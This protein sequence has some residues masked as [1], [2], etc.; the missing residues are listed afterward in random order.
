MAETTVAW[1]VD[2]NL[3]DKVIYQFEKVFK[4]GKNPNPD[5]YLKGEGLTR[6]RLL[7]ELLHSDLELRLRAGQPVKVADYL[8]RYPELAKFPNEVIVLLETEIRLLKQ[9]GKQPNP[10]AYEEQFGSLLGDRVKDLFSRVRGSLPTIPGYEIL[11][12]IGHG[13][14]GVVYRARHLLLNRE[15]ALKLIRPEKMR[16]EVTTASFKARFRR[17][18]ES[19]ASINHPHVVQ[20]YETGDYDGTLF[21]AMELVKGQSLQKHIDTDG[22]MS[23]QAA[24]AMFIKLAMGLQAVHDKQIIHRDLKPENILL[25]EQLEPKISDFGLARPLEG[26]SHETA[27][28]TP[29]GTPAYMSPEQ[30][31]LKDEKITPLVDIYGLGATLYCALTGHAPF[32]RESLLV[33]MEKVRTENVLPIREQRKEVPLDLETICLK[34]LSKEQGRRYAD[35]KV[36][37]EELR[38]FGNN[39]PIHARPVGRVEKT[40]R[41]CKRH[42]MVAGLTAGIAALLLAATAITSGLYAIA[43]LEKDRADQNAVL[44]QLEET[45]AK[46]QAEQT[47]KEKQRAER[48]LALQANREGL[49]AM[50]LGNFSAGILWFTQPLLLAGDQLELERMTRERLGAYRSLSVNPIRLLQLTTQEGSILDKASISA[51]G[52]YKVTASDK[53]ARVW[54]VSTEQPIT[55]PLD[56]L[57]IVRHAVFSPDGRRVATASLDRTARIWDANTGQPLGSILKHDFW[58]LHISFSPDGRR[59]VTSSGDHTARVWD[60]T[61]GNPITPPLHHKYMVV[62]AAF[63]PDGYKVATASDDKTARVWDAS[64]GNPITPPLQHQYEVKHVVFSPDGRHVVTSSWDYTAQ[65]WNAA[66]GQKLTPPLQHDSRVDHAT[67]SPDCRQIVTMSGNVIRVWSIGSLLQINKTLH[68]QALVNRAFFNADSSLVVTASDDKT[69]QVWDVTTGRPIAPS[70]KHFNTVNHVSFSHD[71]S[72]V[73][74]ASS[75]WTARVWETLTGKPVALH[76]HTG[77][78]NHVSFSPDSRLIVSASD[79]NTACVWDSRTGKR[80]TTPLK[81]NARVNYALFSPDGNSV[82]TASGDNT[83][84]IWN[85]HNGK[86]QLEQPL[87]HPGPVSSVFFSLDGQRVMTIDHSNSA[88]LV[89]NIRTGLKLT[90]A[91]RHIDYV[92][93]FT[94]SFDENHAVTPSDDHTARIWDLGTGQ[95]ISLP[96]QHF[97]RVNKASFSPDGR[98]VVTA[99]HD[100]TA[101]VWDASSGQPITPPMS[102]HNWVVDAS[103][104]PDGR[105]VVTSSWDNTARIWNLPLETRPTADLLKLAQVYAGHK[106]DDTGGLQPLDVEKELIP[107]YHEMKAKYPEEFIPKYED[108]RRWRLQQIA[109]CC[110]ER[111][112]PAALFHQ[113]WLLAEAVLESAKSSFPQ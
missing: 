35:A 52:R 98:R 33:T 94:I 100:S 1:N 48:L 38:R 37:E 73:A 87:H 34:C 32:P 74:T 20:I 91:L 111:N 5:D 7:M 110:K 42:P 96:M 4:E 66:T 104:S 22:V 75:D 58:I 64:T 41:W 57:D 18:A 68:H 61:T 27:A 50:E 36:L 25:N 85:I 11:D 88:L 72:R 51:D 107:W 23:P 63:S 108:I 95:P 8:A 28:G 65:V 79:D 43:L 46:I 12:T 19:V 30:A 106:I 102:H 62:H 78:I 84:Q 71:G 2:S 54:D 86:S 17:E 76:L 93:D 70:L 49:R 3:V 82:A 103:F 92:R 101:R 24:A 29:V 80:I 89:W 69:A 13:G 59:L 14:M 55:P 31:S 10:Q 45:K 9:L 99:S 112:L 39:E 15:V 6:W 90:H 97:D 109:D 21:L 47:L 44:A 77:R 40:W 26:A 105:R 56:H 113:N 81:H 53:S 16:D 67:F 60:A 83:V